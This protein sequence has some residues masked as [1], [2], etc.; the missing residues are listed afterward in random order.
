MPK[1][2]KPV[3]ALRKIALAYPET[4]EGSS[5]NKISFKAG[6]KAFLYVGDNGDYYSIM[7]KLVASYQ[8]AEV[9]ASRFPKIYHPGKAGWVNAV[10]TPPEAPPRGLLKLW[11]DESFRAL[12]PKKIVAI[13]PEKK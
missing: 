1:S 13:L 6:N 3:A 12:A 2:T 11:I 5:C 7:L 4:E 8:E 9:L 10:F